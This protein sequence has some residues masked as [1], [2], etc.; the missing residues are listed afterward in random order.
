LERQAMVTMSFV[1]EQDKRGRTG[2]TVKSELAMANVNVTLFE[3]SK[4]IVEH[5][6]EDER[7]KLLN[8]A[9]PVDL[10]KLDPRVGQEIN[11]LI[12]KYNRLDEE[13]DVEEGDGQ[14]N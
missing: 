8:L 6:L 7:G 3:F 12:T 9:S 1:S 11:Q 2:K 4:S 14:G 10:Q 5:N 13:Y